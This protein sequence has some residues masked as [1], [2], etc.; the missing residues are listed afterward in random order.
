MKFSIRMERLLAAI[1]MALLFV[2]HRHYDFARWQGL[3]R[4]AFLS[5][6]GHRFDLYMANGGWVMPLLGAFVLALVAFGVYEVLCKLF[7]L[8]FRKKDVY[9]TKNYVK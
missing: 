2:A 9:E 5:F 7:A 4:D 6:Q 8:F 1:V 3:G